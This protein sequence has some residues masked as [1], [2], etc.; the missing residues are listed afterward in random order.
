MFQ[1][2]LDCIRAQF[3]AEKKIK[4]KEKEILYNYAGEEIYVSAK[5]GDDAAFACKKL[6]EVENP[7]LRYVFL[8]GTIL[9]A[10]LWII[11][12]FIAPVPFL[13]TVC[14]FAIIIC[15]FIYWNKDKEVK[16][17]ARWIECKE[18]YGDSV[19]KA[20]ADFHREKGGLETEIKALKEQIEE[21]NQE[22]KNIEKELEEQGLG[23]ILHKRWW[24][25]WYINKLCDYLHKGMT[26]EE[27][28]DKIKEEAEIS[29]QITRQ[30]DSCTYR[31]KCKKD[32]VLNCA[33][34]I[35]KS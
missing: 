11:F 1:K 18:K 26:W 22:S 28:F 27:S 23:E 2:Q 34:Y 13:S 16:D 9:A 6:N 21:L 5:L 12:S 31:F 24:S 30:C 35:P 10:L 25:M 7:A 29:A 8:G 4:E 32:K 17:Y 15:G 20:I 14:I 33:S 3:D 19:A